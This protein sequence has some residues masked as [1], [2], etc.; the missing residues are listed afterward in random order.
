MSTA[1]VRGL[2]FNAAFTQTLRALGAFVG[3][4]G[5][6][7]VSVAD[8][9]DGKRLLVQWEPEGHVYLFETADRTYLCTPTTRTSFPPDSAPVDEVNVVCPDMYLPWAH[10]RIV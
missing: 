6:R 7:R 8:L 5:T 3:T 10:W 2:G 4:N 9:R 1:R